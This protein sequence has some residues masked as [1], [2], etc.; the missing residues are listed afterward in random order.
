M[1]E[2]F[3]QLAEAIEGK[4]HLCWITPAFDTRA[5]F[6]AIA[7]D[8]EFTINRRIFILPVVGEAKLTVGSGKWFVC[9]GAAHGKPESGIVEWSGIYGPIPILTSDAPTLPTNSLPFLHTSPVSGGYRFHTGKSDP[10]II[11]FEMGRA[12]DVGVRFPLTSTHWKWVIETGF[13]G[14]SDCWGLTYPETFAIRVSALECAAF[15]TDRV[16]MLGPGRVF[17]RVVCARTPFHRSLEDKQ[18]ARGD[19]ILI[20]QRKVDPNMKFS[21]HSEYLRFQAALVRSGH[22]N[23]RA[24]GPTHFSELEEGKL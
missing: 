4:L 12:A 10:H 15:P 14:W 11:V 9:V 7:E 20:Q 18:N 1:P 8:T 17:P 19:G 5:I 21:S 16:V 22:D 13:M 6:V 23:A 3:I 24:V 2:P